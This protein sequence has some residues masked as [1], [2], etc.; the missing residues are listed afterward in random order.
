MPN[1]ESWGLLSPLQGL[2]SETWGSELRNQNLVLGPQE[3][4]TGPIALTES[5]LQDSVGPRASED[6]DLILAR[7]AQDPV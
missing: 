5:S 1:A 2:S 4:R 3:D 7:V 6:W